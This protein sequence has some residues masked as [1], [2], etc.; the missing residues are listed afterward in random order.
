MWQLTDFSLETV[1]DSETNSSFYL[2][3]T[4]GSG[5]PD[6]LW[7]NILVVKKKKVIQFIVYLVLCPQSIDRVQQTTFLNQI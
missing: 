6:C 3:I 4:S 7:E 2:F 1:V 5:K